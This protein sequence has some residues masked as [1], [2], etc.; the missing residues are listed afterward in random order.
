MLYCAGPMMTSGEGLGPVVSCPGFAPS[1]FC[2]VVWPGPAPRRVM[3]LSSRRKLPPLMVKV[4]AESCTTWP[5]GQASI[6][7]WMPA[8]ASV[9]PFP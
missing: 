7:A 1:V 6:A 3:P 8:V 9:A 5:A 2:R 4:P